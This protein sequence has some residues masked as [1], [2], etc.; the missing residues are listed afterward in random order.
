MS[1]KD[2]FWIIV[3]ILGI[4]LLG[5]ATAFSY[6]TI[7]KFSQQQQQFNTDYS[8]QI[9]QLDTLA[10][11]KSLPTSNWLKQLDEETKKL[12]NYFKALSDALKP[13]SKEIPN[14]SARTKNINLHTTFF[15]KIKEIDSDLRNLS[16]PIGE[17]VSKRD[18]IEEKRNPL[19]KWIQ[20]KTEPNSNT[21][22][23]QWLKSS[24]PLESRTDEEK[25][26]PNI[27]D[28]NPAS[29]S[30]YQTLYQD[31]YQL[32]WNVAKRQYDEKEVEEFKRQYNNLIPSLL[33][34]HYLVEKVE[35]FK[36]VAIKNI[37]VPSL[38]PIILSKVTVQPKLQ[39]N[40]SY[41]AY[42]KSLLE[43]CYTASSPKSPITD[44]YKSLSSRWLEFYK[45]R[46]KDE[47]KEIGDI[48]RNNA[49]KTQFLLF[50]REFGTTFPIIFV[51]SAPYSN[52]LTLVQ[53]L[54]NLSYFTNNKNLT[55]ELLDIDIPLPIAITRIS[56][57][58]DQN[59]P[60]NYFTLERKEENFPK[61]Q[62][63][64]EWEE[65]KEKEIT[66]KIEEMEKGSSKFVYQSS[67]TYLIEV[68]VYIYD[69]DGIQECWNNIT[70]SNAPSTPEK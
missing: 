43:F 12:D 35:A 23:S 29:K 59:L 27:F 16:Y 56:L 33:L 69:P 18:D 65:E 49:F 2:P 54:Y 47:E 51:I 9:K 58:V 32:L 24:N 6:L 19:H 55:K 3:I 57:R 48:F 30:S 15:N 38:S 67:L 50:P 60:E 13:F 42:E 22:L 17:E 62:K 45:E 63:D 66:K 4:L 46:D 44:K 37:L 64:K 1:S 25:Q 70:R 34:V 8:E 52:F 39:A 31:L 61:P 14:V 20:K 53:S 40:I 7:S 36:N 11:K 68:L 5:G 28:V 10:Q 26:F 21:P 41:Q